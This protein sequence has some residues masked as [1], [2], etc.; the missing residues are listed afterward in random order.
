MTKD[1]NGGL[2]NSG[3]HFV[4]VAGERR[5]SSVVGCLGDAHRRTENAHPEPYALA[6]GAMIV[7]FELRACPGSPEASDLSI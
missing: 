7:D 1:E 6:S 3:R 2:A 4:S 5:L